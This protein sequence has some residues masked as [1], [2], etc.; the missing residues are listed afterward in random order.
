MRKTV[1]ELSESCR[2]EKTPTSSGM[3]Q[4]L[5]A[6]HELMHCCCYRAMHASTH[7]GSRGLRERLDE[8]LPV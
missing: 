3:F 2:E 1:C 7:A 8:A 6:L 4:S 5:R